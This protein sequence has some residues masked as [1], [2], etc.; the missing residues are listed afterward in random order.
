[1]YNFKKIEKKWQDIW[2][3]EK[4]FVCENNIPLSRVPKKRLLTV[5]IIADEIRQLFNRGI[6][7]NCLRSFISSSV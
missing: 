5:L 3:N 4:A 1:M 2:E 6:Y 7:F